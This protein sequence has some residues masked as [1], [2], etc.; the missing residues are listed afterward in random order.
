[1]LSLIV[2][3]YVRLLIRVCLSL[4]VWISFSVFGYG[5]T[6]CTCIGTS[7]DPR[8]SLSLFFYF[9]LDSYFFL[10]H[11][12]WMYLPMSGYTI[13]LCRCICTSLDPPFSLCFSERFY[14]CSAIIVVTDCTCKC[15]F[16]WSAFLSLSLSAS[17]YIIDNLRGYEQ[18]RSA[19]SACNCAIY[20]FSLHFAYFC[21]S[22]CLGMCVA[23]SW[24]IISHCR[25]KYTSLDECFSLSLS[26]N[27]F[28]LFR[29]Y[30]H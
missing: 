8:F 1:M 9:S 13:T 11:S 10:S 5:V 21:I 6:N 26:L 12:V 25:C 18:A 3:V 23:V 20:F 24:Y 22:L 27:L 17:W 28:I 4:C 14:Y 16:S 2:G 30:C 19:H 29:V 7:L 15:T